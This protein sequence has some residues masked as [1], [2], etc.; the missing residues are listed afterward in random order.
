MS[1][2]AV[3]GSLIFVIAALILAVRNLR[4]HNLPQQTLVKYAL[5]W[6]VIIVGLVLI[7]RLVM[8]V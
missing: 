6:A 7:L 1:L 8:S 5:L 2:I 3:I 4:S